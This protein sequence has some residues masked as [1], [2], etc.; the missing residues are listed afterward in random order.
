MIYYFTFN[1]VISI[2][3]IVISS[4]L[5]RASSHEPGYWDEIRLGFI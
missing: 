3:F 2:I 4:I 1:F 5:L